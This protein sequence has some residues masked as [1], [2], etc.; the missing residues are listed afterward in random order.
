LE[1]PRTYSAN[2]KGAVLDYGNSPISPPS[3]LEKIP[4]N[5]HRLNAARV[6]GLGT[7]HQIAERINSHP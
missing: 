7:V 2:E 6:I 4:V 5:P 3:P 1:L